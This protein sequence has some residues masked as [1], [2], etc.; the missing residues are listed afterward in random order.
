MSNVS[1]LRTAASDAEY[2]KM[3][4]KGKQRALSINRPVRMSDYECWHM[5]YTEGMHSYSMRPNGKRIFTSD[6][7]PTGN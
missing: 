2:A 7:K 3:F 6:G 1:P 5:G 4:E